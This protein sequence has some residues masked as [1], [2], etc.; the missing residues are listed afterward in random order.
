MTERIS[1]GVEGLDDLIEGGIP[2][3][4][5]VLVSGSAGMG[6]TIFSSQ[7]LWEG[8]QNGETVLFITLEEDE[9]DIMGDASEFGW[10]FDEEEE[11]Y[12]E[13]INPF[14]EDFTFDSNVKS[15]INEYNPDRVVIDPVSMIGM[16]LDS[17]AAGKVRKELYEIIKQMKG[18]EVTTLMTT[19]KPDPDNLTRYGVEEY[20]VDGVFIMKGLGFGG[21]MGRKLSIQKMRRTNFEHDIYPI[22]INENGFELKEPEKGLSL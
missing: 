4:A 19:E 9:T 6:K 14:T 16:G 17:D 18:E 1:T 15:Y 22:E 3:G 10:S 7:F 21:D 2:K 12:I 8:V 5:T 20:V 13:Y 11:F